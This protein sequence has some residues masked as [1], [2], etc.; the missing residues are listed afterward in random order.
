[1]ARASVHVVI[2][3]WNSGAQLRECLA[4][5]AAAANDHVT[6]ARVTVV[7]NASQDGSADGLE[8]P[9]VPL[10]LLLNPENRGFAAACNQGAAGSDADFILFLNPDTRLMRGSLERP[11]CYLRSE[12]HE[13]VGIVGIQLVDADGHV[14]R[15]T[16]RDATSWSMIGNSLGLD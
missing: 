12:H 10:I 15:N 13:N 8:C 14:A 7:D 6:L 11:A 5:F 9:S 16:A 2:V 4:S 3:N 1:M